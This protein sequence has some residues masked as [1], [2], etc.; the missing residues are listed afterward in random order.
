[1]ALLNHQ[2]L[3]HN[4][5]MMT[6]HPIKCLLF[7]IAAIP[8][9]PAAA[10]LQISTGAPDGKPAVLTSRD[11]TLQ[12]LVTSTDPATSRA[13]DATRSVKWTIAPPD[14]LTISTSGIA[15]PAHDGAVTLTATAPAA[16]TASTTITI[17]SAA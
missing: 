11:S 2:I 17:S 7:A 13:S 8:A 1:M 15:T 5:L 10:A 16:A 12:L 3:L 6:L 14:S 9:V 4:F